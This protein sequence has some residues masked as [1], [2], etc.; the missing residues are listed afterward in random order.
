MLGS[1]TAAAE[2][3]HVTHSAISHQLRQLETWL[4][5]R[6][7]VR[8]AAG[9]TL[10]DSGRVLY[11][12]V[13]QSFDL[14]E[15]ACAEIRQEQTGDT[16]TLACPGS[17][18]L[19]YL[20]PRLGDFEQQFPDLTLNIQ[21]GKD[22]SKLSSSQADALVYCGRGPTPESIVEHPLTA[23][24]IGPV[25]CPAQARGLNTPA[26]LRTSALLGTRSYSG[27]WAIWMQANGMNIEQFDITR[28]F[29]QFIYMI[30]AAVAGLGVGIVPALLAQNELAD[31]RLVAPFG[32]VESG[33]RIS[34]WIHKSN[35]SN[36]LLSSLAGWLKNT[37][38]APC[39]PQES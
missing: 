3:L 31:G 39:S 8:S 34:L 5:D 23:N 7:F 26:D 21:V 36:P 4:G 30:Q 15:R 28:T 18:M 2:R 37:L 32:F 25:C 29:D 17:F 24:K 14:L 20:I 22:A 16:I 13:V 9:V 12:A 6:L 35:D 11:A 1:F 19:Q 10:T 38:E 27:A 33:D